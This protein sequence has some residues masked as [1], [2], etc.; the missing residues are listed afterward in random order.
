MV[1]S[2]VASVD[3]EG[4]SNRVH[5]PFNRRVEVGASY[6]AKR[7]GGCGVGVVESANYPGWADLIDALG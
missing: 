2:I 5:V 3:S 7:S 1:K 4:V 6:A